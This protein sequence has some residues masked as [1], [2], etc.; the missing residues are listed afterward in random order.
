MK[1]LLALAAVAAMTGS[2]FAAD[3]APRIYA[4]A[5]PVASATNWTGCWISGGGG[6][7]L[8]RVDHDERIIGVGQNVLNASA[9]GDGWLA[10]AGAG[11][12]YQFGGRWL[13]G[14]FADGTWSDIKGDQMVRISGMGDSTIGRLS[15]DWSWAV[16]GRVGY[17][18]TPSVLSYFNAGYTQAHFKQ[19]DFYGEAPPLAFTGGSIPAQ[20][21]DGFFV[22]AGIEY[23]FDGLPG[24]FL[25][26]EGRAA[27]YSR[28]DAIPYCSTAGSICAAAGAGAFTGDID[29]RRPIVYTSKLELVYRFNWGGTAVAKY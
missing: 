21:F 10:T 15:N 28:R 8:Y 25:K 9:G 3:M 29:S 6:Y 13:L 27:I 22:G 1:I 14:A 19:V 11:C 4:K 7:G 5:P 23:A 2:A 26:S 24:L 12:D 17:L 16:G 20:T 18:V